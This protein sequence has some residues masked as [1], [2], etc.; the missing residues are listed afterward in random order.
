MAPGKV[1]KR[2]GREGETAVW[3]KMGMGLEGETEMANFMGEKVIGRLDAVQSGYI[4]HAGI[5]Q[6]RNIPK[7]VRALAILS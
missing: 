6:P 1:R 4:R 7:Y 2:E 5:T 3:I